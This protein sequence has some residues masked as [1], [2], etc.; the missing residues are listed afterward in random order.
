M[1]PR[2]LAF[3]QWLAGNGEVVPVTG[4]GPEQLGRVR[5]PFP[6]WQ[7]ASHGAVI[8]R[9]GGAPHESWAARIRAL[10]LP[11]Q[12]SLEELAGLCS[13][14]F[15]SHGVEARACLEKSRDLLSHIVMKHADGEKL[16]E[17]Y[18]VRQSLRGHEAM[19][20]FAIIANDN[21]LTILPKGI[22]KGAAAGEV[23]ALAGRPGRPVLGFGDGLADLSF[24]TLCD[25]W[26]APRLSQISRALAES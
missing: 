8:L 5:L 12:E 11:L 9:P 10:L 7:I 22:S 24:L 25:W 1:S 18:Q 26:G 16:A 13:G 23:L 3:F 20:N 21:N 15:A 4:R 17:L 6:S 2:Q 19:K 14:H